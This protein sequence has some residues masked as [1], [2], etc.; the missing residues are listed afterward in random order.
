MSSLCLW[1][2]S[3]GPSAGSRLR[4]EGTRGSGLSAVQGRRRP[5]GHTWQQPHW[6]GWL[7]PRAAGRSGRPGTPA[8][9]QGEALQAQRQEGGLSPRVHRTPHSPFSVAPPQ[10]PAAQTSAS[11]Q[12]QMEP[13]V[14]LAAPRRLRQA[15]RCAGRSPSNC[16]L[17]KP[18]A[19]SDSSG[20]PAA[21]GLSAWSRPGRA[22]WGAREEGACSEPGA[23]RKQRRTAGR[24]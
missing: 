5:S 14:P 7:P 4:L 12:D 16:C 24:T 6:P 1:T 18:S 9:P 8:H 2:G 13:P 19:V 21:Q 10:I 3:R 23:Q 20:R 17:M 15:G 22:F 11:C